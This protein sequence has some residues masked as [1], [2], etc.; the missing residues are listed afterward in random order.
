MLL[1]VP[2]QKSNTSSQWCN[3]R[4]GGAECPPISDQEIFADVSGKKEA[5]KKTEKVRS[6]KMGIFYGKKHF[7]PG[8]NQENDDFAPSEKYACYAPASSFSLSISLT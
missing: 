1:S 5:R 4:E 8:K 6:T 2:A 7:T 3:R